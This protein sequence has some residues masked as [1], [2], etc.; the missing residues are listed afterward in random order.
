VQFC[1]DLSFIKS[2]KVQEKHNIT[3]GATV[4]LFKYLAGL[5]GLEKSSSREPPD[6]ILPFAEL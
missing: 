5:D 4:L 6:F 3:S 1:L 2:Y